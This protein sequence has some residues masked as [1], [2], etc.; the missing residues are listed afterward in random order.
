MTRP[1]RHLK[2]FD[3]LPEFSNPEALSS[4]ADAG[5]N[6]ISP[7]DNVV[8]LAKQFYAGGQVSEDCISRGEIVV[9]EQITER[10]LEFVEHASR[11]GPW[12]AENFIR[13]DKW[14][15]FMAAEKD[16]YLGG[17]VKNLLKKNGL[18]SAATKVKDSSPVQDDS[19]Q[20]LSL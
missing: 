2:P 6:E 17:K 4:T 10:G 9:V 7:G 15:E 16:T 19:Q 8:A 5:T 1:L 12:L 3:G 14:E 20:E 11:Y 18:L 13:L